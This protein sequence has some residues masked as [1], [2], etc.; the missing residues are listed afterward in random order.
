MPVR[1]DEKEAE[2]AKPQ[3]EQSKLQQ[4]FKILRKKRLS[5]ASKA[6]DRGNKGY[7][8]PLERAVRNFD[9]DGDGVYD[10]D[11]VFAIVES[12]Q[13]EKQHKYCLKKG[14]KT[15]ASFVLILFA[16]I[17]GLFILMI[18]LNKDF[19]PNASGDLVNKKTNELL[20]THA[21]GVRLSLSMSMS[22]LQGGSNK[23]K[24]KRGSGV[25]NLQ[26]G[27]CESSPNLFAEMD[28]TNFENNWQYVVDGGQTHFEFTSENSQRFLIIDANNVHK[29]D[30]DEYTRYTGLRDKTT[31]NV[32][33]GATEYYSFY[34]YN[35]QE[36]CQVYKTRA[37]TIVVHTVDKSA[38]F[39]IIT[40]FPSN[41][42]EIVLGLDTHL[43][44]Q[45]TYT[46]D[47]GSTT[48]GSDCT[49]FVS[50][51]NLTPN[52]QYFY[53]LLTDGVEIESDYIQTFKTYPDGNAISSNDQFSFL[54]FADAAD[55]TKYIPFSTYY[56]AGKENTLFALQIG[57]FDH[58]KPKT[59]EQHRAVHRNVRSTKY[60]QGRQLAGNILSKMSFWHT[61]NDHDYCAGS[62]VKCPTSRAEDASQA[63]D[64]YYP[65]YPYGDRTDGIYYN[66]R[67]GD[68]EIIMLD[69]QTHSNRED[70]LLG[71]KQYE[72][73]K[74]T[75]LR[76]KAKWKFIVSSITANKGVSSQDKDSW[77]NYENE[78]NL[79]SSFL[80]TFSYDN[81][82]VIMISGDLHTSGA[83]DNGCNNL[84]S[85]PELSVATSN[86]RSIN[87]I[88]SSTTDVG[89]WSESLS[90]GTPGYAVIHVNSNEITIVNKNSNGEDLSTFTIDP[91]DYIKSC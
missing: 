83:I 84:L 22:Q 29:T 88:G 14:L 78:A 63:F 79:V 43:G 77:S 52:T 31:S 36:N 16:A 53:K 71:M 56:S 64:E 45:N 35:D 76:S 54:V 42:I 68:A 20:S 58:S 47:A 26:E 11:E 66:F 44:G 28:K 50:V 85:I 69:T 57:D 46:T 4:S 67:V 59:L 72:W 23:G 80:R 60:E 51:N 24:M 25:R 90:M 30:F 73:L 3:K 87:G 27:E 10:M 39:S 38:T 65:N 70:E 32:K 48:T 37:P 74:T 2:Q 55:A 61:W 18:H 21:R 49:G 86:L 17:I 1:F 8:D 6:V 82:S 13:D 19:K 15:T 33:S 40:N 12:L 91:T 34:C 62:T 5:I 41:N 81:G 9:K 89:I 75:L 7:L